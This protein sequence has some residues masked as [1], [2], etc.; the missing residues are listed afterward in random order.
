ME[1][2]V[3]V[4]GARPGGLEYCCLP[5]PIRTRATVLERVGD[6]RRLLCGPGD[7]QLCL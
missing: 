2:D 6:G 4:V 7:R 5:R 3:V 1:A